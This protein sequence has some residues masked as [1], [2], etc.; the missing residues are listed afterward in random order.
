MRETSGVALIRCDMCGYA[1]EPKKVR[2]VGSRKWMSPED[3][4]FKYPDTQWRC[5]K[6]KAVNK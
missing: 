2:V 4:A 3:I 6:C 5:P 1:P